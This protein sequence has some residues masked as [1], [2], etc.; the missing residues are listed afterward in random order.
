MFIFNIT[1]KLEWSI[2]DEWLK[3]F[4]DRHNK[5]YL[6]SSDIREYHLLRLI[7]ADDNEGPTYAIQYYFQDTAAYEM[8]SQKH[9]PAQNLAAQAIWGD[10]L[11]SFSTLMEIVN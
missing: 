11:L 4:R 2:H 5:E 7:S 1:T 6:S 9:L 8:F 10:K 3:W